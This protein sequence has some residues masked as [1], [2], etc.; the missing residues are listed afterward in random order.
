MKPIQSRVSIWS[1]PG[2]WG[3]KARQSYTRS[4]MRSPSRPSPAV[5]VALRAAAAGAL[6]ASVA[7]PLLRRRARVPA[8]ATVAACASG[9]LALAVLRPRSRGRDVALFALQMWGFIMV[10]ELPFDNPER[11]RSRLRSRYP[12]VL[13]RAV[14]LGRLPN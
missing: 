14:G 2:E 4:L 8:P 1:V 13:D 6:A 7:V 11:L 10:H 3:A 5:R 12:I 9:P